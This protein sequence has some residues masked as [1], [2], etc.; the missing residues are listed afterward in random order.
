MQIATAVVSNDAE[1]ALITQTHRY[2]CVYFFSTTYIK[3][4]QNTTPYPAILKLFPFCSALRLLY[5]FP[6]FI[7]LLLVTSSLFQYYDSP[8]KTITQK[9]LKLH[10]YGYASMRKFLPTPIHNHIFVTCELILN[11]C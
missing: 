2:R 3:V 5:I 11:R 4:K 6:K 7:A 8:T 10:K 1:Y 9:Q